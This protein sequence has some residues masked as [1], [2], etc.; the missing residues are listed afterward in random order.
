MAEE[1]TP[2]KRGPKK[3]T[4]KGKMSNS[5]MK[6]FQKEY[7]KLISEKKI[8]EKKMKVYEKSSKELGFKL[9][10]RLVKTIEDSEEKPKVKRGR[11]KK[12]EVANLG[13]TE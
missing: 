7:D 9:L 4:T 10:K 12:G 2:K 6:V 11:K 5:V 3:G 13:K 1:K 8:I